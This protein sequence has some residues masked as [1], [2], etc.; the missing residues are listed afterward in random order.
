MPHLVLCTLKSCSV[1]CKILGYQS[2]VAGD[3]NLLG[4]D[5]VTGYVVPNV[6]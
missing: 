4:C 1:F 2:G 3:S 5:T 6:L